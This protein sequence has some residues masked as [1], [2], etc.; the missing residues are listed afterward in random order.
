MRATGLGACSLDALAID[1]ANYGALV[2]F[3]EAEF[4]VFAYV[5]DVTQSNFGT[6]GAVARFVES[7]QPFAVG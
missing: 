6:V 7:R 3:I 1:T 4:G 2:R 5:D